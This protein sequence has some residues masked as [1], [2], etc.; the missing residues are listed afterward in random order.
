[1][2][3]VVAHAGQA[4]AFMAR[5]FAAHAVPQDRLP[6][7]LD[8]L[9]KL[10]RKKGAFLV[11]SLAPAEASFDRLRYWRGPVWAVVNFMIAKGLESYGD[12]KR[13]AR[14]AT[15]TAKLIETNG[16]YEYFAPLDGTGLGGDAFTW[17]AAMWL[18]WARYY[19]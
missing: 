9:D 11:P 4:R 8:H 19:S 18:C 12:D 16:F 17:T 3:A 2:W 14:I 10:G 6:Q 7:L 15:D 13:A 5:H 1:M